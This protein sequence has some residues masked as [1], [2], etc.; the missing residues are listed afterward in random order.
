MVKHEPPSVRGPGEEPRDAADAAH[1]AAIK[2]VTEELRPI[3]IDLMERHGQALTLEGILSA[4][5]TAARLGD[6]DFRAQVADG[7]RLAAEVMERPDDD[8]SVQPP[9]GRA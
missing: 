9:Q 1:S 6:Q 7:L 2:R 8:L 5:V 3:F 4:F